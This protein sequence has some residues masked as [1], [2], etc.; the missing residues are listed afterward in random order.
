MTQTAASETLEILK[1][2]I[3]LEM[4]GRAL[5]SEVARQSTIPAAQEFFTYMAQ[6][7]EVHIDQLS[8]Q[9]REFQKSGTFTRVDMAGSDTAVAEAVLSERLRKEITAASF[10]AAAISAA[11][12]MEKSAV[13][14]YSERAKT[15]SAPEEKELYKWLAQWEQEH[16]SKL[17]DLDK[18]ITQD[19]WF[20]NHFWPS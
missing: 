3:L 15:A 2:A 19:I 8:L 14:L 16:L 7:E 17:I 1:S 18:K 5:Y 20:D 9:Y 12:N 11:I 13:D 10:E 4:R 6:E